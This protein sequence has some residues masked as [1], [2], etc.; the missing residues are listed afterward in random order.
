MLLVVFV[1]RRGEQTVKFTLSKVRYLYVEFKTRLIGVSNTSLLA[2][3]RYL[4]VEVALD[5]SPDVI[6]A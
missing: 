2:P 1:L 4:P 6:P 3:V 5:A